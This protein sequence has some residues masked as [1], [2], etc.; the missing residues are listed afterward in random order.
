MQRVIR[1]LCALCGPV[2]AGCS[3][4]IS[5]K[6]AFSSEETMVVAHRACWQEAPENSLEAI[7]ACIALGVDMVEV[8]VRQTADGKLVLLHDR[9]LDRTSDLSG[10]LAAFTWA[11]IREARLKTGA[12]GADAPVTQYRIPTLDAALRLSRGR[13]LVN[14]DMKERVH[15]EALAI[16]GALEIND[17]VL[18]K[19]RAAPGSS[20][21]R[22]APFLGNAP[23]MPIVV[24]CREDRP[25]G[26]YCLSSANDLQGA[27][28]A[29]DP[30]AYEFVFHDSRFL[31]EE[32]VALRERNIGIWVNT[33]YPAISGGRD[34]EYG[35][36]SPEHVWGSLIDAGVSIIQTD[37]P[38]TL[39]QYLQTRRER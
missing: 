15:D 37:Y 18:F 19:L 29:Y 21:L 13:I 36:T 28:D 22:Q 17:E 10:A 14:L 12:G 20:E 7:E 35:S 27:F 1:I 31:T 4:A 30:V 8:D 25:P 16:V 24:Q 6:A 33:L 39:M 5:V 9:T 34:D 32:L 38:E 2:L 11:E 23:F 3:G 26:S